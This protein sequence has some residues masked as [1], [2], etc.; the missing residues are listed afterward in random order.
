MFVYLFI[1]KLVFSS[2]K[3][4]KSDEKSK[5]KGSNPVKSTKKIDNK[6]SKRS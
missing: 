2:D 5:V 4:K 3:L 1:L 6:P